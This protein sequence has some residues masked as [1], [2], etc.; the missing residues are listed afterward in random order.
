MQRLR[1]FHAGGNAVTVVPTHTE[2]TTQQ[3]ADLLNVSRPYLVRLLEAEKIPCG[4]EGRHAPPRAPLRR[5][6]VQAP[7]RR[8]SR[9][10]ASHP[11]RGS[12]KHRIRVLTPRRAL[13]RRAVHRGGGG[14]GPAGRR[15]DGSPAPGLPLPARLADEGAPGSLPGSA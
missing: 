9:G 12:R 4:R 3:A 1:I 5:A 15:S 8:A 14:R 6:R 13:L 10:G 2:L 11:G 7:P